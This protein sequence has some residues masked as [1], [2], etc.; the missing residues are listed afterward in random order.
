[1]ETTFAR[2]LRENGTRPYLFAKQ[3]TVHYRGVYRLAGIRLREDRQPGLNFTHA[4]LLE[5]E[6]LTGIPVATLVADAWA[7]R[8]DPREPRKYQRKGGANAAAE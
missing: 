6:R 4:L 8:A 7:A 3:H 5:I 2:W 1:M